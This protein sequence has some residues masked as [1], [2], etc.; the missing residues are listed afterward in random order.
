[1][2]NRYVGSIV[3]IGADEVHMNLRWVTRRRSDG[4]LY[5]RTPKGGIRLVDLH[6]RRPE[7][8]N[9]ER[10]LPANWK[11]ITVLYKNNGFV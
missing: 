11:K 4:R 8:F 10:I 3:W 9:A 7:D 2:T 5:G 6:L 1:M